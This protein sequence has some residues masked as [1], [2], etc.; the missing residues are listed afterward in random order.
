M[1]GSEAGSV[2]VGESQAEIGGAGIGRSGDVATLSFYPTKN[3]GAV[4]DAGAVL[5]RDPRLAERLRSLRDHGSV[6][7]YEHLEVG[8]NSRLDAIQAAVLAV[9]LAHLEAW[10]EARRAAASRYG[11]LFREA[12]LDDRVGLPVEVAD[13]HHVFHQYVVRVP[14]RDELRAHLE[15]DGI[16]SQVFYPIPLHLQACFEPLGYREGDLP[17]AERAAREVLAIPMYAELTEADQ[18]RVVASIGSFFGA[19]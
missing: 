2:G 12:G 16:G 10:S 6:R 18:A 5:T 17:E 9:K 4:G 15:A 19:A 14:R 3:L 13:G 7:R 8:I 1:V 11:A